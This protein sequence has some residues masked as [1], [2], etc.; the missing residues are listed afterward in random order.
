MSGFLNGCLLITEAYKYGNRRQKVFPKIVITEIVI[1]N[2]N[3][4]ETF[5]NDNKDKVKPFENSFSFFGKF[6]DSRDN[7]SEESFSKNSFGA[8]FIKY[9]ISLSAVL[10]L[11]NLDAK[12]PH[13]KKYMSQN[14]EKP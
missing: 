13:I 6:A 14:L 3:V 11:K 1:K 5:Q 7:V 10:R 8:C 9:M 2:S 4:L 12:I